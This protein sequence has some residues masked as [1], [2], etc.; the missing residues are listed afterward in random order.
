[1][2]EV[3]EVLTIRKEPFCVRTS[4][5]DD[6]LTEFVACIKRNCIRMLDGSKEDQGGAI[7]RRLLQQRL[8]F[9][10]KLCN[11]SISQIRVK[12]SI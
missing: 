5:F 1:M 12:I 11:G 6:P 3:F 10:L 9:G 2:L 8:G 7:S 4:R